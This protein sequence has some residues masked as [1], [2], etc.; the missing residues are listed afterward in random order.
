M[1]LRINTN[2]PSLRAIRNLKI[3][4]FNQARSLERLSTGLRINRASDDPSGLVISELLRAQIQSLRQASENT[5]NA[6]NMIAVADKALEEVSVLLAGIKESVVFAMSEGGTSTEQLLAEQSSIDNA[7]QAIARIAETTRFAGKSLLSGASAFLTSGAVGAFLNNLSIRAM[8]FPQGVNVRTLSGTLVTS[9]LRARIL[10]GN[11]G[12]QGATVRISGPL[13]IQEITL[14]SNL[15]A[16]Q[17]RAAINTVAPYTGVF[18]STITATS[19]YAMS[20][21]YGSGQAISIE[22]LAGSVTLNGAVRNV[23][24][25]V[26]SI[27]RDPVI[28]FNGIRYTGQG[29][30]FKIVNS[31]GQFEFELGI[32]TEGTAAQ[33]NLAISPGVGGGLVEPAELRF[34]VRNSGLS[35]QIRE[36]G[37]V[38]DRLQIGIS[39]VSPSFLG[40]EAIPDH[41]ARAGSGDYNIMQGGYLISLMSGG[42]NDIMT[43]NKPNALRIVDAALLAV[44]GVRGHLG[45]VQGFNLEPNLRAVGVAVENLAASESAIR[46]LDF[47]EE[48]ANFTR[49]QILFQAGT[50]V[51]ASANLVPQAVLTLL[52]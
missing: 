47:A 34:H 6:N 14:A 52:R 22:V 44:T 2:I 7:V 21:E 49:T 10:L 32:P 26:D 37:Y 1:G 13:G 43:G 31:F 33:R 18:A 42:A 35:F 20:A 30:T 19:N 25:R 24:D 28:D 29:R 48:T 9:A 23:G 40:F 39:G 8:S 45:A 17:V 38:S 15:T 3:N 51:L 5:Q 27:G 11:V 41:V 12:S 16:A 36:R 4:D 46:D 50:A